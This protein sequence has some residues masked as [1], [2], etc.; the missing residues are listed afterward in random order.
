MLTHRGLIVFN[1]LLTKLNACPA[2]KSCLLSSS[3]SYV[4]L[5]ASAIGTGVRPRR[6]VTY[7]ITC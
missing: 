4:M 5:P 3:W 2:P 6:L 1:S 7:T